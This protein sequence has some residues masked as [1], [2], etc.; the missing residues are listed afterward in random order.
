MDRR[1]TLSQRFRYFFD[2]TMSRGT[3]AL[4]GW[5]LLLSAAVIVVVSVVVAITGIAPDGDGGGAP[6]FWNIAWMS[7]MRT[8]DA[9][10]MGGDAG[11]WP[12]LFAMLAVTLGGVFVVSSLIGVLTTGVEQQL[13]ELRKGR[14]LV[15]ERGHTVILGWS[16]QITDIIAELMIANE[17]QR[18]PCIAILADK[19]KVEME[20]EIRTR[21]G[22]T[23]RTRVICRSGDPVDM[24]ALAIVSP[25]AA[26][27]V[28]VLAPEGDDADSEVIKAVLAL[29]HDPDR[30]PEPYH[31]VTEVRQQTSVDVLKMVAGD[32]VQP[33][34]SGSLVAR[35]IAQTSRQ[36]G[37]S[38]VYTELLDFE[39][40]E[41]YFK[42][43]PTLVGKT[44]HDALFAYEDS[45]VIGLRFADGSVQ[46]N[47]P[48]DK[49]LSHGDM[50]VAITA[51]DDTMRVSG[52]VPAVDV[53]MIKEKPGAGAPEVERMLVL[54]W[55]ATACAI[56]A[57]LDNYVAPGSRV[58]IVDAGDREGD[59]LACRETGL[60][61]LSLDYLQ[62]DTTDRAFLDRL[63]VPSFQHV[64][65][66]SRDG[67]DPQESDAST[68]LTLL[69]LRDI[70]DKRGLRFSIVSQMLDLRNRR[71]AEVTR[72]DDFIVS[73]QLVSL[74]LAMLSENAALEPVFADLFD[75]E[76]SEVYLKP[77][78]DYVPL[79]QA[80][81]F[82]TLVE[83]A[84]RRGQ[85][86]MGYRIQEHS[87]DPARS[88]G[89]RVNPK[90]GD[91]V[92]FQEGDKLVVLAED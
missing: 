32:E 25:H 38:V 79:G 66:L 56:I 89:V 91:K 36:S 88:Y 59:V 70:S 75:P 77:V 52:T 60:K 43:E 57:E 30:S 80:V 78:G 73:G 12:F 53:A 90:K 86:A 13:D 48:M 3:I 21:I 27:S 55:N 22:R 10:T 44:F 34:L 7:L 9:G 28:I 81:S 69:H 35:I 26:R 72:A 63:D 47:P 87:S 15:L 50:I 4:I 58:T 71:L 11:N 2:N 24:D 8:L 92:V 40:D 49:R 1:R 68:L 82:G 5:L 46:L 74:M 14:S 17:N 6:G 19:D 41:I 84:S 67:V 76:G 23:G 54:G 20:D 16:P 85:V 39:G 51:D 42:E 65:V 64:I 62:G 18:R 29:T 37:L 33:V 61:H 83:A 45:T 31:I